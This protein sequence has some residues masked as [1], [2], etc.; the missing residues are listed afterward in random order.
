MK[1]N[2]KLRIYTIEKEETDDFTRKI[3]FLEEESIFGIPI[4]FYQ[5]SDFETLERSRNKKLGLMCE[6]KE[7]F[8]VTDLRQF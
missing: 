7:G 5:D 4:S 8:R 1:P 3:R 6:Y 2:L